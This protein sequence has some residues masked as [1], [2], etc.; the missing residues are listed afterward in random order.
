MATVKKKRLPK[1]SPAIKDFT[2]LL[3]NVPAGAWVA[4][5]SDESHVVAYDSDIQAVIK[6]AN[7]AGE[8]EPIVVRVP[9]QSAALIV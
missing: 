3:S 9:E 8:Q 1:M 2:K 4:I 5:S 7:E 6:K